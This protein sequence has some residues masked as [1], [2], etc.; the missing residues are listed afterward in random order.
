MCWLPV[1]KFEHHEEATLVYASLTSFQKSLYD[2]PG[3]GI[4][5]VSKTCLITSVDR[6]DSVFQLLVAFPLSHF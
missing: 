2:M 6:L 5:I 3:H 1:A 4:N